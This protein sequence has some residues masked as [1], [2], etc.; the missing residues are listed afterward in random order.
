MQHNLLLDE[1]VDCLWH[2]HFRLTDQFDC[3]FNSKY[4]DFLI[5]FSEETSDFDE[6]LITMKN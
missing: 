6:K 5:I 2:R 3:K 1:V 4:F